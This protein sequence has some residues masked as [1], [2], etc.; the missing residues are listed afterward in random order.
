MLLRRAILKKSVLLLLIIVILSNYCYANFEDTL[1][2]SVNAAHNYYEM[3]QSYTDVINYSTYI[4]KHKDKEFPQREYLIDAHS[5][6]DVFNMELEILENFQGME[7][8]SVLTKEEGSITYEVEVKEAGLYN[9]SFEYYPIE[10]KNSAIQRAIFING[11]LPFSEV[12]NVEFDRLWIDS[13]HNVLKDNQGNDLRPSQIESPD[14]I[15]AVAKDYQGHYTTPFKFYFSKGVHSLTIVSIREPMVLRKIR[16]YQE[17]EIPTYAEKL[18][19]YKENGY[20]EVLGRLLYFEAE[21]ASLKSSQMLYPDADN[22]SPA[23]TPYSPKLNLNNTI[24]GYNWR[25][26]GQWI[27]WEVDVPESGLYNL[28]FNVKQNFVRGIYTSRKLYINGKVPFSNAERIPFRHHRDW[29]I[30][31]LGDEEPYLFYFKEGKNTIRMEAVLG[32]F[33]EVIREVETG[34]RNLNRLYR[35]I[36]SVTGTSPDRWRDYQV[37]KSIPGIVD[38]MKVEKERLDLI[39]KKIEEMAGNIGD[40]EAG[41]ISM[42]DQLDRLCRDVELITRQIDQFKQNMGSM[43]DWM[44]RAMEQPLQ[45][46]KIYI[47]SSDKSI[48]KLKN[49][50]WNRVVHEIKS[51]FYSFIVNYNA[52]GNVTKDKDERV[53]TVWVGTGR[54]Q[55][56]TMKALID[57]DFTRKTGINVNLMLVDMA[58]LLPATLSGQGPD[59]AMQVWNDIPMNYG[60]R[61]A[62]VD[63]TSFEDFHEVIGQFHESAMVPYTF[64]DKCFALPEQLIF[65][66]LFYRKDIL[67]DLNLQYPDTWDEVKTTISVLSKNQMGFGLLPMDY[68]DINSINVLPVSEA[69][70]GMFLYQNGGQYYTDD[71]RASALDTDV[72]IKA[73]REF[74]EYY[75]DYKLEREFDGINRFRTGEMPLV[76]SDYTM[77]NTLQVFAPEIRGLWGFAPVPG[78][79]KDDGSIRRDVPATG[80]ACIMMEKSKDK[81]ASWEFMKWWVSAQ[82]QTRFGVEMEALMGPAAR[83]PTANLEALAN[84]P[85]PINDYRALAQQLEN[86]KGI[87]QIPGGYFNSRHINNAFYTVVTE[88]NKFRRLMGSVSLEPREA[89]TEYVRY[90]NDEITYKRKEFGLD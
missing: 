33:S 53:I 46:D 76:I 86:V 67:R 17:E 28:G 85:W 14:W 51:L 43:A 54:D 9:I 55:A 57:E 34:V 64:E 72:A 80:L 8:K 42:R 70:F 87:P 18:K 1:E 30:E 59:V 50:F 44:I 45:L 65:K 39:I 25:I 19:I 60:M 71:K 79:V 12:N 78:T 62:V 23:V 7:G 32:E 63:L 68:Y 69:V 48:P 81:E 3:L 36:L 83:Y 35:K 75:T 56:N 82:T 74:T 27:E 21:D 49:S 24:G 41:L 84:L 77:Y 38:S 89:I 5:Y 15:K 2:T 22:S 13:P 29:R 37:E 11:Q 52:I 6:T 31:V 10:G 58:T 16:I 40:R 88:D 20:K 47:L 90:I 4:A 66:M 61:N 73:F 26:A